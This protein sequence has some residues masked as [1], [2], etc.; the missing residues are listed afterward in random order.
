MRLWVSPIPRKL[1]FYDLRH[2]HAALLRK[3]GVD[4]GAVQRTLG[5]SSPEITADVYDHSYVDDFRNEV[6]RALTFADPREVNAPA[7]RAT[8]LGKNEDPGAAS[9]ASNSG[10]FRWSGRL[11]LNQRP[12]AP[13]RPIRSVQKVAVPRNPWESLPV[14]CVEMVAVRRGLSN[15]AKFLLL[16]CCW[17]SGPTTTC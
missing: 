16:A 17:T 9:L 15:F 11:D 5:H 2:S 7:M 1:R 4:L 10:A 13:Q 8:E 3:A 14:R 12:L 6:E